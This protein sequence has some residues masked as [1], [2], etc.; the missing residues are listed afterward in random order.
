LRTRASSRDAYTS[1]IFPPLQSCSQIAPESPDWYQQE[2]T[3]VALIVLRQ[4]QRRNDVSSHTRH[5][6][7]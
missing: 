4:H 6:A 3:R 2:T 7:A 1:D 5:R